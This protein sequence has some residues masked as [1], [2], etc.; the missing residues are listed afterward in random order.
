MTG[1]EHALADLLPRA[2]LPYNGKEVDNLEPFKVVL[3]LPISDQQLDKIS[4]ETWKDES[5]REMYAPVLTHPYFSMHDEL[6]IQDGLI[7]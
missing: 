5:L 4:T 2:Y 7:F 3:Y 6:T 1:Q